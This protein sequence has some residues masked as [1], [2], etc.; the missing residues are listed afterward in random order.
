M[1]SHTVTWRTGTAGIRVVTMA[2][3]PANA[4]GIGLLDGLHAAID[5]AITA[6]DTKV[7]VV[8]SALPGFFA[9]GADIKHLSSIDAA[10]FTAYGD[11]MR[12]VNDRLASAPFLSIAAIDGLA[13]GGGL[14]LAL[15]C[16]MRVAGPRAALG[17]PEVKI[18]LIPGAG[19]TQR[20]TRL[21]G[22]ARALDIML[23]ARQ[24]P[25]A[26]ALSI[27]LVDRLTD[28][29]VEKAA[30]ALAA[31]LVGPSLPA[32][33]AIVRAVDAAGDLPLAD[34][35]AVEVALEQDLFEK[36]EAA[37]GITAFVEKRPPRFA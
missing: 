22:R 25:P 34:G 5:A 12:A 20:L 1:D 31:E 35:F 16:T 4:L 11:Q 10:S 28:A 19:G 9:A 37:E 6:G 18:G 23:T 2:R 21:V 15:G 29:D 27:G 13:L 7:M 33:L 32:Q 3:P 24:V 26:E 14:E 17:L 8:T 36:G 30:L